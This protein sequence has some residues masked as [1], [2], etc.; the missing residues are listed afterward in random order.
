LLAGLIVFVTYVRHK[1]HLLAP[2][3]EI[4]RRKLAMIALIVL[5]IYICLGLLDSIHFRKPLSNP[6][7]VHTVNYSVEVLSVLDEL[8]TPLRTQI[9]ETY[10]APFATHSYS[11]KMMLDAQGKPV[12]D[13]PRLRYGGAQLK[14]LADRGE[15]ILHTSLRG[16]LYAVLCWAVIMI[17]LTWSIARSVR[18]TF[19]RSWQFIWKAQSEVPWW[20]ISLT[21]LVILLIVVPLGMLSVHYHVFGTDKVGNDVLYLSLKSIRTGLVIGTL[22]TLIMLPFAIMLGIMAGYYR[23]WVDDVIQ[24]VYTTLNS[25][26]GILLIAAAI[27]SI[28]VLIENHPQWFETVYE[29]SD[30]RLL[31]LCAILGITSW[32]SLCRLLRGETLKLR[33]MDYIQAANAFGVRN[34]TIITRHILPNVMHIVLIILVLDFSGLVLAESVLSYIGVGVDQSTISWGNMI[35]NARMEL[36]REPMVWW[37]LCAAFIMMFGLVLAANLFADAVRDAF[38]PRLKQVLKKAGA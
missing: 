16:M 38:D 27:L 4:F 11:K 5:S 21:L 7:P 31:A 20:V 35:N 14:N 18:Q 24:Y 8:L 25:I 37:S 12:R 33:E 26:P 15:D 32:T 19:A 36:A 13:Y 10:S 28:D 3:R 34:M 23:G 9:E 30:I 2:W 29:R 17:V 6:Q 22:T 1:E